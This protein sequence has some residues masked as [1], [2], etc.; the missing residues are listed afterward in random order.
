MGWRW[1]GRALRGG[2]GA[3]AVAACLCAAGGAAASFSTSAAPIAPTLTGVTQS[4]S[5]WHEGDAVAIISSAPLGT[6]FSFQLNVPAR[7]T[8]TF[9]PNYSGRRVCTVH[10]SPTG[11]TRRCRRVVAVSTLSF[12]GHAGANHVRFL[13]RL[14]S[15]AKLAPASY[16]LT[17]A[18]RNAVGAAAP[19]TLHF[20]ILR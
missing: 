7:V 14:S 9:V 16:R 6:T 11:V 20:T 17:I 10:D 19:A 12:S 8:F 13:G 5:A 1:R 2:V 3:F 4:A 15:V 18:A